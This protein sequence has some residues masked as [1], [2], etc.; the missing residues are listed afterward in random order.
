MKAALK[1]TVTLV[2]GSFFVL[3]IIGAGGLVAF[4]SHPPLIALV[5]VVLLVGVG[6]VVIQRMTAMSKD[7]DCAMSGRKNCHPI[8]TSSVEAPP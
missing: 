6:W 3:A 5:V 4:V 1:L 8:D 2:S 7:E